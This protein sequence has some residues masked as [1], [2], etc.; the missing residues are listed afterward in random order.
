MFLR[1]RRSHHTERYVA[2]QGSGWIA[3]T[4]SPKTAPAHPS[5]ILALVPASRYTGHA[6]VDCTGLISFAT[7]NI[8]PGR[9]DK[10]RTRLFLLCLE[11][12]LRR[13]SP[14]VLVLG[15]PRF[16]DE[17]LR[18]Q[19][20]AAADPA[21]RFGVPV[22]T[23]RV[24]EARQ[25]LIGRVRG[26]RLDALADRLASGFFPELA[27]V[28]MTGEARRYHRNSFSAVALALHALIEHAPLAAAVI[29]KAEAFSMGE[30]NAALAA[31]AKR[32]FPDN[33]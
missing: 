32:H 3:S 5:R 27:A 8:E 15:V 17:R 19:R 29:A 33:L 2:G 20:Q 14:A 24:D 25:L 11:R 12:S 16:D 31:S 23:K 30:F 7:W 22:V 18:A 26:D 6:V 13:Y 9:A 1:G 4:M 28:R 21:K 10:E